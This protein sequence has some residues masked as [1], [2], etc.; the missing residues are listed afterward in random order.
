MRYIGRMHKLEIDFRDFE[1]LS[2]DA[3]L[4]KS[5]QLTFSGSTISLWGCRTLIIRSKEDEEE[6]AVNVN[7][8]ITDPEIYTKAIDYGKQPNVKLDG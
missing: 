7:K 4:I 8:P 6:E 3:N 2:I 1:Y 5:N